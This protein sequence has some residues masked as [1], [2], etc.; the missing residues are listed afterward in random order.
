MTPSEALQGVTY[1][2]AKALGLADRLGTLE[3]GK[4]ADFVLWNV[5]E[6]AEL[7]YRLGLNPCQ[8]VVRAGVPV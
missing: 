2:A 8:Q 1:N 3:A 6:P 7:A 5:N 4:Q